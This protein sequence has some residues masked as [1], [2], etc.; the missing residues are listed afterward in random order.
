MLGERLGGLVPFEKLKLA[1][2]AVLLSPFLPLLFMG[3]EY[4]ETAPFLYFVSHSDPDLIDAVR[5][6]RRQEFSAFAWQ[7]EV[8]DPQDVRTFTESRLQCEL[9][10]TQANK[11]LGFYRELL[12]LRKT[13]PAFALLSKHHLEV[14]VCEEQRVLYLRRWNGGD[15]ALVLL[16]FAPHA[17]TL[18][19]QRAGGT[20]RK[21]L[22]SS[23]V[24]W[25]GPGS[26]L[27][28][29]ITFDGSVPLRINPGSVTV[30]RK[31]LEN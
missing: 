27:P 10:L 20:W 14:A 2:A 25:N 7:G 26:S 8:P 28:D 30:Y 11:L 17:T 24:R 19:A 31:E 1:A 12:S 29:R 16:C 23:D 13:V 3:E 6:G 18:A 15:E 22:D 9:T 21:V 5:K 4:G